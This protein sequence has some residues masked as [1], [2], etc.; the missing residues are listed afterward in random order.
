[1]SPKPP[2]RRVAV[3][4]IG[5]L[6]P[7]GADFPA[8]WRALLGGERA[9]RPITR[10]DATGFPTTFACDVPLATEAGARA[11]SFAL[12]AAR[13]S[14]A[15]SGL[16]DLKAAALRLGVGMGTPDPAWFAREVL[17]ETFDAGSFAAWRQRLPAA[18][19]AAV[20]SDLGIE[21]SSA[22]IHTACASSAQALGEA[23]EL[24]ADGLEDLVVAG[25]ADAMIEPFQLA[26]FSLLGALSR[27]N[28]DPAA[29]CKPFGAARDG[30]VLGEGAAVLVLEAWDQAVA[31]GA[32]ILGEIVGYGETTSA[33][34]LTDL[35]PS[36]LGPETAMRQALTSA[37][38]APE[39]I[40]YVN[41]H[42]TGTL[43]NDRVEAAAIARVLPAP[44]VSSTKSLTGHL[45]AAAGAIEAAFCIEAL[46]TG[47]LP[48][49]VNV[50]TQDPDC[51]V[52][53]TAPAAAAF[54]GRYA[55]SN[56]I[57]FGG[58]NSALIF[59]ATEADA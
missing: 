56:S 1:M 27:D 9:A 21:G 44:Q 36:G 30:F 19:T 37:G 46:R 12:A 23:F 7:L 6:S 53:L 24:I 45:I 51:A 49:S 10:F 5:A 11:A 34:R 50:G 39:A 57:G 35:E 22:T 54:A 17:T 25:G 38:L 26:G 2:K 18:V 13:E 3:T 48:P 55:L 40:A 31:R 14:V 15:Q 32:A 8:T 58:S 4:G 47:T 59:A 42:G 29:A 16:T 43:L 41:A 52:T 20:A 33:Y 28:A